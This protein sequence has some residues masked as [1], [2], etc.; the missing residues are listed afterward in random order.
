MLKELDELSSS[1]SVNAYKNF[2]KSL[3]AT[4]K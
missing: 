3:A 4:G 1:D 2:E